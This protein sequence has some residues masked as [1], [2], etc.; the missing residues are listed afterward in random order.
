MSD[1]YTQCRLERP[2]GQGCEVDT[3]FIPSQFAKKGVI[4]DFKDFGKGWKVVE[5][6]GSITKD[7]QERQHA[8]ESRFKWVLGG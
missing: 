3:A 7:E 1:R 4:L 6:Y 8:T 2:K 5:V